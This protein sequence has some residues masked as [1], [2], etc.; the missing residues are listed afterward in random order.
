M[1][2]RMLLL[3]IPVFFLP[4]AHA[5]ETVGVNAVV[6][7]SAEFS[8]REILLTGLVDRVS[9]ARRMVILID[10]S[11]ATCTEACDRKTVIVQLPEVAEIP[12]KGSFVTAIGT[13]TPGSNPLK[14]TA[15]SMVVEKR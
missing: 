4:L 2:I 5:G 11:E 10:T 14:L 8:D 9:A 15:T 7:K 13:L 3:T 1:K 6:E 12:A